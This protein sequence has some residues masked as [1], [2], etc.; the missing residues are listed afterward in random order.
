MDN[1]KVP[2]QINIS[3]AAR[4]PFMWEAQRIYASWWED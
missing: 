4:V 2:R 3:Y 1:I